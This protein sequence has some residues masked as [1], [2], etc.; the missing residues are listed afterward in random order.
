MYCNSTTA[1]AKAPF[2]HSIIV[3]IDKCISKCKT[4][5]NICIS[6]CTTEKILQFVKKKSL[7]ECLTRTKTTHKSE[8][9][10]L[11]FSGGD[12]MRPQMTPDGVVYQN[13]KYHPP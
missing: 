11:F 1:A 8:A 7:C 12:K 4:E 9:A 10:H 13:P 2:Q 6:K 3:S 5:K